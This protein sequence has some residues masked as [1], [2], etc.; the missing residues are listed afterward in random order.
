MQLELG[1]HILSAEGHDIGAIKHLVLDPAT[2]RVKTFVVEKGGFLPEDIEIP[3]DALQETAEAGPTL[4]YTAEQSLHLPRF[5][6]TRYRAA[7]E[8]PKE[9]F[10][11]YPMGGLLWP[12][13]YV[14]SPASTAGFP[15]FVPAM[16]GQMAAQTPTESEEQW[17][18][19]DAENAV[20]SAGDAVFSQDMEK[21]GEVQCVAFDGSTGRPTRLTVRQGWLF[22]KDWELPPETI[23]SVDDGVVYLRFDKN[24]LQNRRE[25]ELYTTEWGQ[26]HRPASRD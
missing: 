3:L 22:H 12:N 8:E 24:R 2:G 23:A 7:T 21:V 25:E 9:T 26:D 4:R 1:Q 13:G 17:R 15:L 5:E 14:A 20:I 19:L 18:Q 16:D 11:T 6:E 10:P